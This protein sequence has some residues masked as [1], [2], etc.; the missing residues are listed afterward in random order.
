MK[1]VIHTHR[2][3]L[4][5]IWLFMLMGLLIFPGFEAKGLVFGLIIGYWP[6]ALMGELGAIITLLFMFVLSV[7]EIGLCEWI[8]DKKCL[9]HKAWTVVLVA[10]IFGLVVAY[11]KNADYYD[12][13]KYSAIFHIM[14]EGYELTMSDFLRLYL[15]PK[16]IVGGMFCF[17]MAVGIEVVYATTSTL[18][19]R[20]SPAINT[21]I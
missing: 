3:F 17:Y 12:T 21:G 20:V 15:I 13:W 16:T 5:S 7:T 4:Y 11:V 2:F 6:F 14:P 9:S 19:K 1:S 10:V 8:L 18:F